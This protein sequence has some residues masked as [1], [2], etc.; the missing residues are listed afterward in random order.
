MGVVGEFGPENVRVRPWL[1]HVPTPSG[2]LALQY[3]R[4]CL[5]GHELAPQQVWVGWHH[6][7]RLPLLTCRR[8]WEHGDRGRAEW[9]LADPT[10]QQ[11]GEQTEPLGLQLVA[12]PPPVAAAP[13]RIEVRLDGRV[14]TDLDVA[15]CGICR[16]GVVEHVR[17]DPAFRRRGLAWTAVAAARARGAGYSWSTTA[18][19]D[20]DARE[21]W[22]AI[23]FAADA[24]LGRARYCEH[25]RAA[26]D[27]LA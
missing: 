18:V 12:V 23:G 8:C 10:H 26:W 4:R 21:F 16:R 3:P 11:H 24:E 7:L 22:E 9:C 1:R 20:S 6:V 25:M 2:G 5:V 13:G 17:T 14:V 19:S 27:H 15:L